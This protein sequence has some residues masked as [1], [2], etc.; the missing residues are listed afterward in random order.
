MDR[1]VGEQVDRLD[2]GIPEARWIS[3]EYKGKLAS[4][5]SQ[6]QA[7]NSR[8][9][10][11]QG[12]GHLTD[13]RF[14]KKSR[15]CRPKPRRDLSTYRSKLQK[16]HLHSP[17]PPSAV[18]CHRPSWPSYLAIPSARKICSWSL[19]PNIHSTGPSLDCLRRVWMG[20][21]LSIKLISIM[22]LGLKSRGV[23]SE[24]AFR[25]AVRE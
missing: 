3:R 20:L 24:L 21:C 13:A 1:Q 12:T 6:C 14:R 9:R 4:F 10:M 18:R 16:L 7:H 5:C 22:P 11:E 15:S 2:S 19:G 17:T 23:R 25:T 8:N